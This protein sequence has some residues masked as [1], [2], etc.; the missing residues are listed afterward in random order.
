M[1]LVTPSPHRLHLLPISRLADSGF[2]A[3]EYFYRGSN[4]NTNVDCRLRHAGM[5]DSDCEDAA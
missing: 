4:P 3:P 5:A 2:V 1:R